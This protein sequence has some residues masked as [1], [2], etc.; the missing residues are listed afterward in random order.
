MD[1][2]KGVHYTMERLL[3]FTSVINAR[4]LGGYSTSD[5]K[6]VKRGLLLRTGDLHQLSDRELT[7]LQDEYHLSDIIDLRDPSEIRAFPDRTIPGA[8]YHALPAIPSNAFRRGDQTGM[9]QPLSEED[10]KDLA[11]LRGLGGRVSPMV[12][13]VYHAL[14]TDAQSI[15]T[16]RQMFEI[17]GRAKG[18]VLW[19]C[20]Y[21]KDRTGIAAALI[22]L[23]L[24]VEPSCVMEDYLYTNT[25]LKEY[26]DGKV[27]F[28]AEKTNDSDLLDEV[29]FFYSVS[30]D[31]LNGA[32]AN[33]RAIYG[34]FDSF[35]ERQLGLTKERRLRL[36]DQ[37]LAL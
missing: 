36:Q 19:H 4:E 5:G 11:M 17:L 13:R 2:K 14:V 10:N 26:I 31:L 7:R 16:F 24:K 33:I 34:S 37:Y 3:N 21:G 29:R 28:A 6:L 35:L 20:A 1:P 22:L 18:A 15:S 30:P 32:L 8:R 25:F 12:H 27:S 9:D 23:A